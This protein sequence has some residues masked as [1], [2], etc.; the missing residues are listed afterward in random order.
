M[1]LKAIDIAQTAGANLHGNAAQNFEAFAFDSRRIHA[2]I[3]SC[4]IALSDSAHADGHHYIEEAISRGA[5]TIICTDAAER[6]A[7]HPELA[8]IA[9][10]NPLAVVQSW[11]KQQT[12][13]ASRSV[14]GHYRKYG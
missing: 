11:A 5:T 6:T 8:F 2:A 7:A 14:A 3:P 4:F 13:W 10:P 12:R 1:L 9:H